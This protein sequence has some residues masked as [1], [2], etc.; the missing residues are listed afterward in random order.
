MSDQPGKRITMKDIA[1][2][3][4]VT[5]VTVSLALRG[6]PHISKETTEKILAMAKELGYD[7]SLQASARRL[8]LS[9]HGKTITNNVIGCVFPVDFMESPYFTAIFHGI[10]VAAKE[11][12]VSILLSYHHH[13]ESPTHK[14]PISPVIS[15]GEVDGL[16]VVKTR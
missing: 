9:R 5:H 4:G 14:Y 13:P 2:R 3:C 6:N 12:D 15:R 16:I 11:H 10:T 1:D 8:A 7:P